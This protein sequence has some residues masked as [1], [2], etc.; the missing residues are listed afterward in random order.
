M[1][2]KR[3]AVSMVLVAIGVIAGLFLSAR[4]NL[5]PVTKAQ[6]A[7]DNGFEGAIERVASSVGNA[8]VSISTEQNEKMGG[9]RYFFRSPNGGN[10]FG[11]NSSNDEF[12]RKFFDDFFGDMPEREYKRIGLGSGFIIDPDGTILTNQHV[13]NEADK[14]TV[15]LPDGREFKA[16]IKGQDS[17]SDLAVIK[18]NAKELPSLKLGDSSGLHIGQWVVA[19]GN[20]FG[21]ALQNP[22]PTVTAGVISALHRSLG[23]AMASDKNY[24]DLIQT[25]A[26]INPGN[27]G[28]PL[29]NLKGEVVGINVAIFSTTGGNQGI[30]FAIPSNSAKRVLA[31]LISGKT[32]Q[33]GW[34]GITVQDLTQDL[35]KYFGLSDKNGVLVVSVLADGPA[36]KSGIKSGDIIKQVGDARINSVKE[37]LTVV[38][39]TDVG[40]KLSIRVLRDKK[41]ASMDV[42]VGARPGEEQLSGEQDESGMPRKGGP[43]AAWRGLAVSEIDSEA[44]RRLNLEEKAGV[45]VMAVKPNS[46]AEDAGI[47]PGD[48]IVEINRQKVAGFADYRRIIKE[49][50]GDA[51]VVTARGY[52]ILKEASGAGK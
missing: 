39:N 22:E 43:A 29:V 17:R 1:G 10:P 2:K 31:K 52:V 4:A 33:Y 20:P 42:I 12:F 30:G 47:V 7:L 9:K 13:V 44:A 24:N 28:G 45:L 14:V 26:A 23:R 21:F 40:K 36:A 11:G 51:L 8:V 37:L 27:S 46:P 16:E 6:D 19:A 3:L 5:L 38:G 35:A 34:L 48:V 15:T 41:E 25:D 32:I 18:I 49:L 50:K